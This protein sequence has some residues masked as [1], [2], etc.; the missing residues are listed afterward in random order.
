MR[1]KCCANDK[2]NSSLFASPNP[3]KWAITSQ[4]SAMNSS[5]RKS[6]VVLPGN[7]LTSLLDVEMVCRWI[8]VMPV[9]WL[10]P[11]SFQITSATYVRP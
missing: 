3:S 1:R 6:P 9:N 4:K 11:G 10:G 7:E 8:I 5:D 2:I